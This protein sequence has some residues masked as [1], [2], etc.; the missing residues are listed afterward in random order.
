MAR[1]LTNVNYRCRPEYP[2]LAPVLLNR[3]AFAGSDGIW[4]TDAMVVCR[5]FFADR[6]L[7]RAA[8]RRRVPLRHPEAPARGPRSLF[9]P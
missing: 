4:R 1:L 2:V 7:G 8:R 3:E 6:S 9:E 5:D